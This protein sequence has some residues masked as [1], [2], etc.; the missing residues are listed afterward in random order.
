MDARDRSAI[1]WMG[2]SSIPAQLQDEARA[3]RLTLVQSTEAA[4]AGA[5]PAGRALA[6]AFTDESPEVFI[7][8]VRRCVK[9]ALDHGLVVLVVVAP[10][11]SPQR[12]A[13]MK[14]ALETSTDKHAAI[15]YDQWAE[16]AEEARQHD[17]GPGVGA[18]VELEGQD[19]DIED[20]AEESEV[21]LLLRRAFFDVP[22][23]RVSLI[24]RGF[25]GARVYRIDPLPVPGLASTRSLPYLV[26]VDSREKAR[27][28]REANK[29]H[30]THHVPFRFRPNIDDRRCVEGSSR[31]L[32]VQ[33]FIE[34]GDSAGR[35]LRYMRPAGVVATLFEESL[36]GFRLCRTSAADTLPTYLVARVLNPMSALSE[37]RVTALRAATALALKLDPSSMSVEAIYQLIEGQPDFQCGWCTIHGDLHSGNVF[38]GPY[39]DVVLIDFANASCGPSLI[40]PACFEVSLAWKASPSGIPPREL[41]E[42]HLLNLYR[43]P[44]EPPLPGAEPGLEWRWLWEAVRHTRLHAGLQAGAPGAYVLGVAA[45][46]VRFASYGDGASV[47]RRG[48]AIVAASRLLAHL[49]QGLS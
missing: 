46:L 31:A 47:G 23:I 35:L 25:S 44:L 6:V 43:Y 8:R 48:L 19:L 27:R 16:V 45:Y 33:D 34:G 17:P 38:V 4:L 10:G 37:A 18:N 30:A 14:R 7:A 20:G 28:E 11:G 1:L 5:S 26:K 15:L 13:E 2:P 40:D 39:G 41:P 42:D 21:R 32:L 3:R 22:S 36:R 12:L 24:E 29:A 49:A 9:V